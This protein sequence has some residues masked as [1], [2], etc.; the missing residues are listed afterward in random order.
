MMAK[1][2]AIPSLHRDYLPAKET[3]QLPGAASGNTTSPYCRAVSTNTCSDFELASHLN[4][5]NFTMTRNICDIFLDNALTQ[6]FPVKIHLEKTSLNTMTVFF[7]GQFL[8][9][10]TTDHTCANFIK[11]HQNTDRLVL[12]HTS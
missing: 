2:H 10:K 7:H 8:D 11:Y 12:I 6:R 3:G 5:L 1:T 4:P 9:I